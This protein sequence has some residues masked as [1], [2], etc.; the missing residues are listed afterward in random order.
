M[1]SAR[2]TPPPPTAPA[3]T[4]LVARQPI[5]D[6]EQ[7]VHAY[8][9][10]YRAEGEHA[11]NVLDGEH[12]TATVLTSSFL[13]IG[14]ERLVESHPAYINVTRDFLLSDAARALPKRQVVLEILEDVEVDAALVAAVRVLAAEGYRFALDDFCFD[15]RWRELLEIAH[16][17][18]VDVMAL[19]L[20]GARDHVER[21]APFGVALLAEKVESADEYAALRDMGYQYFQ[22]YFF[23][24]P[25]IVSGARVPESKLAVLRL[26]AA[27]QDPGNEMDDV[28][29]I[30]AQDP[31]LSYRVLRFINSAFVGLPTRVTTI[32]RAV[33]FVGLAT[34]RRWAMLMAIASHD[35]KPAELVRTAVLRARMAERIAAQSGCVDPDMGFTVGLFSCL[36][37]FM[38][39]PLH[40]LLAGL[41]LAPEVPQA[42]LEHDGQA[43]EVVECVL[44]WERGA[45]RTASDHALGLAPPSLAAI[46]AEAVEYADAV[47]AAARG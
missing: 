7:R 3:A 37:A 13:D 11:A 1:L 26:I 27:L 45:W 12:A 8:E 24:R 4:A 35:D 29:A 28:A 33:T 46:Y 20:D 6:R 40:E 31:A 23:A 38:D 19:G 21:L 18:K 43:G 32:Q 5:F 14:L 2:Q 25:K 16:V 42:L 15:E 44:A 41:P 9:L 22:G 39:R 10:L 34:I 30:V 36:D 17:V 47:A